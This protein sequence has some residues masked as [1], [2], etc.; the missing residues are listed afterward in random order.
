MFEVMV[1]GGFSAAH[2]LREYPGKCE[3]LHGHNWTVEVTVRSGK[4]NELDMVMDFTELKESL[5]KVLGRLDHKLLNE[6]KPFDKLSSTS[7]NVAKY[8]FDEMRKTLSAYE[9]AWVRVWESDD[10]AATYYG[11]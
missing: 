4:L 3:A 6:L 2:Q 9:I 7:E 10:S 1:K 5:G 8:V 11:R